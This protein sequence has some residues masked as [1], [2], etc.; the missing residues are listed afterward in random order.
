MKPVIH[1]AISFRWFQRKKEEKRKL[2]VPLLK[3]HLDCFTRIEF[4]GV[5]DSPYEQQKQAIQFP[6]FPVTVHQIT[7]ALYDP[8]LV[9]AGLLT[10]QEK[11]H[12]IPNFSIKKGMLD[13]QAMTLIPSTRLRF[14]VLC[15]PCMSQPDAQN[16]S[17]VIWTTLLSSSAHGCDSVNLLQQNNHSNSLFFANPTM[18]DKKKKTAAAQDED[19]RKYWLC[20]ED[21]D[22]SSFLV[23]FMAFVDVPASQPGSNIYYSLSKYDAVGGFLQGKCQCRSLEFS[24]ARKVLCSNS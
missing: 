13:H 6:Y 24:F 23:A 22:V 19:Q 9:D 3:C 7:T 10:V 20:P 5:G 4:S 16:V 11:L 1:G 17:G 14:Q 2:L 18:S 15:C 21:M 8:K 12:V